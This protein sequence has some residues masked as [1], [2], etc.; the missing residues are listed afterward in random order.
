MASTQSSLTNRPLVAA[1]PK[2]RRKSMTDKVGEK[3]PPQTARA[4]RANKDDLSQTMNMQN[5]QISQQSHASSYRYQAASMTSNIGALK[6][7]SEGM[8]GFY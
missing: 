7:V 2:Q 8:H 4:N 1:E 3:Q 5:Y 6:T